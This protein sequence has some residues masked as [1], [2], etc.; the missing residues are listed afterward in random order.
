VNQR[1]GLEEALDLVPCGVL[2][3]GLMFRSRRFQLDLPSMT[4]YAGLAG[5]AL[6]VGWCTL[7][8]R[9]NNGKRRRTAG[10]G[11]THV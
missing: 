5:A 2:V 1:L 9:A 7:G 11:S 8:V 3:A 6:C 4:F 10:K